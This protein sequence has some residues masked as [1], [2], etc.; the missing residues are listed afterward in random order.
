MAAASSDARNADRTITEEEAAKK[1]K[2]IVSTFRKDNPGVN[3][4]VLAPILPLVVTRLMRRQE[5][6]KLPPTTQ[7]FHPPSQWILRSAKF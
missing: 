4:L 1:A 7:T 2:E 5:I 6:Q 3:K